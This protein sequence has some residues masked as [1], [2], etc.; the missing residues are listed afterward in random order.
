[1]IPRHSIFLSCALITFHKCNCLF[2]SIEDALPRSAVMI[3]FDDQPFLVVSLADGSIIYFSLNRENGF[4][5]ERRK[6]ALG[7]KPTTLAVCQYADSTSSSNSDRVLIACTDRPTVISS[8][9]GKLIFTAINLREIVTICSLNSSF[10]GPSLTLVNENGLILGRIDD[11]Q[12]LHVRSLPLAESVRRI[13]L[14]EQEK[15]IFIS[16]STSNSTNKTDSIVPISQ[17]AQRKIFSHDENQ[18]NLS[19]NR[20]SLIVLDQQ[21]H[22]GKLNLVMSNRFDI[23]LLKENKS[24]LI[25]R[26]DGG[27]FSNTNFPLSRSEFHFKVKRDEFIEIRQTPV[28]NRLGFVSRTILN[29]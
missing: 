2:L 6:I 22:Q 16:T 15:S 8:S 18:T 4:L 1:M 24:R 13:C 21:T 20:N 11:L 14:L 9:N 26:S 23:F 29:R 3:S 5:H 7:T 28:K 17:Q 10:F 27:K 19:K 25:D 12:K